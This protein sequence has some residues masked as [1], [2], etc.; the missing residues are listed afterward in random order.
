[1]RAG[2]SSFE[3]FADGEMAVDVRTGRFGRTAFFL[4]FPGAADRAIA[5]AIIRELAGLFPPL[6]PTV[7]KVT[8]VHGVIPTFLWYENDSCGPAKLFSPFDGLFFFRSLRNPFPVFADEFELFQIAGLI[9]YR[10]SLTA[11][12]IH[13]RTGVALIIPSPRLRNCRAC[14]IERC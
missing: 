7:G 1:M 9:R 14:V 3:S 8:S 11:C 5:A 12:E 10:C 2:F 4:R 6:T 13:G